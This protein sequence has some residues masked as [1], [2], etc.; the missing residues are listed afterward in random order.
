MSLQRTKILESRVR[1]R[2][3][4]NPEKLAF[5]GRVEIILK[6]GEV[7][8]DE[9]AVANAHTNGAR[10]FTRANY[11]Q[12]FKTLTESLVS[13]EEQDRFLDLVA[14]LPELTSGEVGQ[15]NVVLDEV[16]LEFGNRDQRGIF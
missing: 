4:T 9:L 15:L 16:E 14:R 13:M 7:I 6:N 8:V 2:S 10:P 1:N 3:E 11:I 12:K 5:G